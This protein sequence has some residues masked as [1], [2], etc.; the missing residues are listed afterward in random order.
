MRTKALV[1]AAVCAAAACSEERSTE[2]PAPVEVAQPP[3]ASP[4]PPPAAEPDR[5]APAPVLPRVHEAKKEEA[6][7]K[8]K[9]DVSGLLATAEGHGAG[10]GLGIA[11]GG[12]GSR[13]TGP[14]GGRFREPPS[15]EA[16]EVRRDAGFHTPR[17]QPLSTFAIDVDT[18]SYANVRRILREGRLPP[19]D[20]VK[21]EEMVNYFPY[22]DPGPVGSDP[23]ALR[24]EVA[25]APWNSQHLLVRVG[26]QA[27]RLDLDA[28]PPA[29]LVFLIDVSGSMDEPD[30][31]PLVQSSLAMLVQQL[32]PQD[33]VAIVVYA[34]AAGLVLPPTTGRERELILEALQQLHA[35]GST[36]GGQGLRLAYD[37][38]RRNLLPEGNNRVILAT[39]GDFN[40]GVS[41]DGELVR[42]IEEER[43]SGVFLTVLGF[44]T[45]NYQDAKMEKL[46]DAGNGNH[47]YVDTLSEARKVLVQQMGGTLFTLAKDVKIQVE[48]NPA[49]VK[50]YRLLG[51]ENRLLAA[52]DF[53]DDAKDA[54]ELGAGH[55]VTALYEI[56]PATSSE[57]VPA[58]PELKY[59]RSESTGLPGELMTVKVRWQP[60]RGGRSRLLTRVVPA[61]PSELHRASEDFRFA[62]AVAEGAMLLRRSEHRAQAS[63][64]QV[65]EL[66][67]GALGSD[68][69]GYR[70]GFVELARAAQ[71]LSNGD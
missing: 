33:Q 16:Y 49:H 39:D 22:D 26:L 32:R 57:P 67:Q 59:Q 71:E 13:G 24:T 52:E 7:P 60:P 3:A 63:W 35:G 65:L 31:L 70:A 2:R 43:K 20:A 29:N 68:A 53:E 40:V 1:V 64:S 25:P 28:L 38:A 66:A 61:Q 30:K 19:A 5:M 15:R 69:Q 41:S 4:A 8:K 37:V 23:L 45:G 46:A 6:A 51:Y 54:G 62:A 27:R 36:A 48:P 58:G 21:V 12:L 55:A 47:A 44:G 50:S 34:G 56:V 9:I 18:A 42:L 11:L 17:D 14:G 10:L